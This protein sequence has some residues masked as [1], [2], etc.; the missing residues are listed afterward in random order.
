MSI[1]E[2]ELPTRLRRA[3]VAARARLEALPL[4]LIL[5]AMRIAIGFVFFN[6][7]L[8]KINSF[9]FAV[10]LF[11]DEYQ[12]PFID[13]LNGARLAAFCELVF[14][15][16]LI[17]GLATRLATL[18]LLG[19]VAV[20]EIFVYPKA[21]VEHLLWASVLVLLLTRGPGKI[22]FDYLIERNFDPPRPGP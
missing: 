22:S 14:P 19:M 8:L 18:P 12:L 4:S 20:I 13:P 10:R 1:A 6:S 15:L 21:W 2:T 17:F 7:G 11:R 9:E 16:F 3:F 5:L